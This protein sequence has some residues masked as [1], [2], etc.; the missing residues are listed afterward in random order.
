MKNKLHK[1][2]AKSEQKIGP[3]RAPQFTGGF[4]ESTIRGHEPKKTVL[5]DSPHHK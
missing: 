4:R 3:K 5:I 2:F 1:D